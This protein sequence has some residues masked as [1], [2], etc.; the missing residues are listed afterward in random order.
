MKRPASHV[1]EDQSEA[2]F[3]NLLPDEWVL[4]RKSKDYGIDLEVEIVKREIVTGE[5]LWIQLKARRRSIESNTEVPFDCPV[6]FLRYCQGAEVPI[7]LV[8]VDIPS[9]EG[10]WLYMQQYIRMNLDPTDIRWN[11]ARIR[12]KI[13][14]DQSLSLMKQRGYVDFINIASAPKIRRMLL[15]VNDRLI[16]LKQTW[17]WALPFVEETLFGNDSTEDLKEIL[18]VV[19]NR[20]DALLKMESLD[21]LYYKQG[22]SEVLVI[23]ELEDMDRALHEFIKLLQNGS[24]DPYPYGLFRGKMDG[25]LEKMLSALED[26][27]REYVLGA[28]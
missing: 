17:R 12:I 18:L 15:E 8:V 21:G 23:A 26:L 14:R 7:L 11:Q 1:Q 24:K 25:A 28:G 3:R 20:L 10:Y 5:V 9:R 13:P 16:S 2:I 22:D 6:N 19:N 4:R 27:K